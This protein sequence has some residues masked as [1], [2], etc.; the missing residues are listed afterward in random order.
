[1]SISREDILAYHLGGKVGLRLAREL[2]DLEALCKAYTPGV[3]VPVR[4]IH[5]DPESLFLYTAKSNLVA[6]VTD[7]TAILG[8]GDLGAEASIPVMEG[9][10]VLFKA[11]GD[12]DGWP[13]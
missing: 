11:F 13:V 8:L 5:K 2:A 9:K 7:G 3:A 12:V 4:E 6:V 1:M 10:A